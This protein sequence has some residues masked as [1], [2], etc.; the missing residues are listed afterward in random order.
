VPYTTA[1]LDAPRS[2]VIAPEIWPHYLGGFAKAGL[3]YWWLSL[4]QGVPAIERLGGPDFLRS[5][6]VLNICQ[7]EYASRWL[8]RAGVA[9]RYLIQDFT[10]TIVHPNP[11]GDRENRILYN[12]KGAALLQA[13]IERCPQFTF[14]LLAD[15][16]PGEVHEAMA[17]SKI[18]VDFGTHP[19]MDRMPREA[20]ALG[21]CVITNRRGSAA[22]FEDVPIES[23][24][25][26][27][28]DRFDLGVFQAL[29]Q[30]IYDRFDR[31]G[32]AFDRY[33][34]RIGLEQQ[35][36]SLQVQELFGARGHSS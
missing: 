2:V 7:S 8:E 29:V 17:T 10:R 20:A 5:R 19:G 34:R 15:M 27:D 6:G 18:F 32:R 12:R 33:R 22:Y 36:F 14:T 11:S 23:R 25:K 21:C 30:D 26:F 31:H 28:T 1:I 4:D 24:Y 3:V 9:E 16:T 13:V 35:V